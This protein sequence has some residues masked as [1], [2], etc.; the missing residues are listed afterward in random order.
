MPPKGTPARSEAD[1]TQPKKRSHKKKAAPKTTGEAKTA[2]K[3]AL[4]KEKQ[5]REAAE[6]AEEDD[7]K[8]QAEEAEAAEERKK[9]QAFMDY[10]GL[11][12]KVKEVKV[13]TDTPAWKT[14]YAKM[15]RRITAAANDI[16][17]VEKSR[18]VVRCQETV[19]VIKAVINDVRMP[20]DDLNQFCNS[21]PL[22]AQNFSQMAI[23][24][25][26]IGTV[27]LSGQKPSK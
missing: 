7:R 19:K 3:E 20:V 10:G 18:D 25:D 14:F 13:M 26:G 1:R 15:K 16:L 6:T 12:A 27:E 4:S 23:F 11:L 17:D 22:F 2:E 24:N 21:M 5:D 9:K 8:R